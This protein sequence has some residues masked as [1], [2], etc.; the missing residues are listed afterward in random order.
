MWLMLQN[1]KQA[2]YG[3]LKALDFATTHCAPPC[4][5]LVDLGG[6]KNIF[7]VLM[8]KARI[9][10]PRGEWRGGGGGLGH[11]DGGVR[12]GGRGQGGR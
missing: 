6:L 5:K 7:G 4:D 8:G 3:A 12:V 2:R 10:G 1:K 11:G 9:K